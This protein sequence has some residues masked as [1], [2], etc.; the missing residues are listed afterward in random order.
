MSDP[1]PPVAEVDINRLAKILNVTPRRIQQLV[2]EGMPKAG[3]GRYPLV[4][5]IHWF[6][7][8]WQDR[9]EGRIAGWGIN[10]K[11]GGVIAAKERL[12]RTQADIAQIDYEER[13]G[14]IHKTEECRR[15]AFTLGRELR[16]MILIVPDRVDAILAAENDR[17]RVNSTLRQE[18]SQVLHEF[19]AK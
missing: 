9:A 7:K 13:I 4:A 16:D 6:I 5:C 1:S 2:Q 10:Q 15:S 14:S 3:K 18:L 8:F 12:T 11:K 19:A 17:A